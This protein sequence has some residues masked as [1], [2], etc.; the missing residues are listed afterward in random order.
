MQVL[1]VTTR[2]YIDRYTQDDATRSNSLRLR[3]LKRTRALSDATRR[4]QTQ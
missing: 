3:L 2:N 4:Q 1:L